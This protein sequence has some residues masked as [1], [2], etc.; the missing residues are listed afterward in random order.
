MKENANLL[1]CYAGELSV[2]DVVF[3]IV[4]LR[5]TKKT[6]SQGKKTGY[7]FCAT[8]SLDHTYNAFMWEDTITN[9]V[10]PEYIETLISMDLYSN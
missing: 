1:S 2:G 7:S 3:D 10:N 6:I 4:F 8:N 5:I 9:I